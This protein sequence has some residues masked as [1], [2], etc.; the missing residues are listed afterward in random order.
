MNE[1]R[2]PEKGMGM[3]CRTSCSTG[4]RGASAVG[5]A[6]DKM[7]AWARDGRLVVH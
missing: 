3:C 1:I 6:G 7:V 4:D 5:D 2:N